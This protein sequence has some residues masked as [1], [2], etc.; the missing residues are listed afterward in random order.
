MLRGAVYAA[1]D[2]V[3][4]PS[5]RDNDYFAFMDNAVSRALDAAKDKKYTAITVENQ[6]NTVYCYKPSIKIIK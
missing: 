2:M 3:I 1:F 4:S 6:P 5:I